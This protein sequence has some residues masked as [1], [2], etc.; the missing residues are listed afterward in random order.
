MTVFKSPLPDLALRDI[1]ITERVFEGL[2]DLGDTVVLTDGPS[3]GTLT[4]QEFMDSVKSL[5]GGLIARG[6]GTV[7]LMAPNMPE[8]CTVFHGVAWA[9]GCLTTIN[10]AYTEHEVR[11]QLLDSNAEMLV[12]I[13]MFLE[14]AQ[15]AI[16][17]TG[18]TE[19]V[20]IGEAEGVT[21]L[22]SLLDAPLAAQVPV[23]LDTHTVVLP[24][25]SGTTGLPKGVKLSHR[26]LVVNVD[27]ILA[28]LDVNRGDTTAAFLPFFH[29][30]GM[31][32]L[33]NSYLGAGA[34]LVTMPRFDMAMFLQIA[35]DHKVKRLWCVPPVVLALAK[36]PVVDDYDLSHVTEVFSGAAPLGAALCAEVEERIGCLAI[37]GYG[38]T[39]L[40]PVSH[41][42]NITNNHSG[43]SGR[44]VPNTECMILD[45]E[46]GAALGANQEG[47][48][49]VRGPQVMQGYLNN[50]AATSETIDSDGWLHT[51]DIAY[52]D[53]EGY[54]F[55]VDRLKELIKYK[56]FQVAPAEIEAALMAHEAIG[57]A[58]VIGVADNEAGEVPVAFVVPK[59]EV[60]LTEETIKTYLAEQLASYKQV[61][62][63]IFVEAIP[64]SA[65]GKILRRVLREQ[66]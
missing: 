56:G 31:T 6:F 47:A 26:N 37:Q 23:D 1:S 57:D 17:G 45:V 4:A 58:G 48:L 13:P 7:A 39:E 9:G 64:K 40:S 36:M 38:M 3:G 15:A 51:G 16:E 54:M 28:I 63:V 35:Q 53:D 5:A 32:A 14:V 65:S 21:S 52:F 66:V 50:D 20:V 55:I 43:A 22:A 41:V 33:M 10:P 34:G 29:I 60:D 44:T 61:T 30:Y 18:V 2:A 19:I 49:L 46:S 25:S 62:R 24:Y 27:Q 42:S 12:T 8:Y 11:H 59:P